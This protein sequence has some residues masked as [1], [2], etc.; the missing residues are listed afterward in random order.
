MGGGTLRGRDGI[1]GGGREWDKRGRP[2]RIWNKI[3][4]NLQ[5]INIRVIIK[6]QYLIL[7]ENL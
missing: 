1:F 7:S 4:Q 6:F 5:K 3:D 2:E